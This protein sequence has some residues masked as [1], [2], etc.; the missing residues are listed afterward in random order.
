MPQDI[1]FIIFNNYFYAFLIHFIV[2]LSNFCP[3]GQLS[4]PSWPKML[5]CWYTVSLLGG[6]VEDCSAGGWLTGLLICDITVLI[7]K[8]E[9]ISKRII[10]IAN[11]FQFN[12]SRL[13]AP[14]LNNSWN[15]LTSTILLNINQKY[16][17]SR[18]KSSH[19]IWADYAHEVE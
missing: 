12:S 18:S 15:I 6:L 8:A 13:K 19:L 10:F 14:R 3:S 9:I 1:S 16:L 17:F 5:A 2:F 11:F 4:D 7:R